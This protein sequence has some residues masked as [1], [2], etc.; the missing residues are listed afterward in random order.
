MVVGPGFDLPS[1]YFLSDTGGSVST[2]GELFLLSF[3]SP[4]MRMIT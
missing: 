2:K 4:K 3:V 1:F